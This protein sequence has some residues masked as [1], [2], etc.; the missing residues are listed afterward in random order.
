MRKSF[1]FTES[2]VNLF[3]DISRAVG[4]NSGHYCD[5]E[6]QENDM[7]FAA[8]D[9]CLMSLARVRGLLTMP[10]TGE[11]DAII[12]Q[13]NTTLKTSFSNPGYHLQICAIYDPEGDGT[14][15]SMTPLFDT[16]RRIGVSEDGLSVLNDWKDTLNKYVAHEDVLLALWT[17]PE[18][19]AS[20]VAK[21]A[22]AKRK[23]RSRNATP[24]NASEGMMMDAGMKDIAHNHNALMG[25][26]V[27]TLKSSNVM[28]DEL[29]VPDAAV[30]IRKSLYPT[31]MGWRPIF[32]I[33]RYPS[34]ASE[35]R[36]LNET[37]I[38]AWAAPS[39][40]EQ[41]VGGGARYEGMSMVSTGGRLYAPVEI[42]LAPQDPE[43]YN[44][45]F[46]RLMNKHIP[47][48]FSIRIDSGGNYWWASVKH[49]ATA[50]LRLTS[51]DSSKI[52][53]ALSG[54]GEYAK[55]GARVGLQMTAATWVDETPN[56]NDYRE[57]HRRHRELIETIQGWGS[58]SVNESYGN[59][60]FT[61][62]SSMPGWTRQCPAPIA[63]APL[64]EA[65]KMVPLFR[66]GMPWKR[67][68]LLLRTA[69]GK[70]MPYAQGSIMQTAWV[71]IGISPMGYGKS[72][73][74]ST[75][76]LAFVLAAGLNDLGFL[77]TTD[78]GPS[79]KGVID[80]LRA[81]LVPV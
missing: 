29:L 78:I 19:L 65:L 63:L 15:E 56:D 67:G 62:F 43:P 3:W 64:P 80:L 7:T 24:W 46:R 4:H 48:V 28:V 16:A 27:S 37:N 33:K 1:R 49:G 40:A 52:N 79:S 44:N 32:G 60:L 75:I 22:K 54:I 73:T 30:D 74:L 59:P 42:A 25:A 41:L 36:F 77:S 17:T 39:L 26:I 10:G 51:P 58:A 76:N 9:G 66:P 5:L 57:L 13:L 38:G 69:D 12:D 81:L 34:G 11:Y 47:Y 2:L 70:A 20:M 8:G 35:N 50:I 18:V 55:S 31:A 14:G 53:K 71:D 23:K 68:S 72:V 6:T 45:L 61:L 21:A